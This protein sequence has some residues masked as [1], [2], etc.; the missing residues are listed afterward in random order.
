MLNTHCLCTKLRRATRN[1]SHLYDHAL[2]EIG[3]SVAQYSLLRHV[4]RLDRPSITALAESIGL[5]R[6]T[7]GRNLRVL[8]ERGW[9]ELAGGEDQRNRLVGLS[10]EGRA[11]LV[12]ALPLWQGVQE[13]LRRRLGEDQRVALMQLL[14]ELERL[15]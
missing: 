1:V 10:D 13:R 7:L 8:Q 15:D 9:V 2:A 4:E 11:C 6:S 14:D 3:L 12:R 5:E